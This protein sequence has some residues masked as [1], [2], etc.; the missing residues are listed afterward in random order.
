MIRNEVWLN[1][2]STEADVYDL[3]ATPP[4]YTREENGVVVATRPMTADEITAYTPA[5][6]V[7]TAEEKLA[8]AAAALAQIDSLG[9]PVLP[10][11]VLDVL[12]DVRT[13][14]EG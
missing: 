9:A 8:A 11:D 14:L 6:P 1:G 10:V 13:A 2:V 5:P 3:D 4:T 12:A 7:L